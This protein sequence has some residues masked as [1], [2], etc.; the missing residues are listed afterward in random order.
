[1]PAN[2]DAVSH[3]FSSRSRA[4]AGFNVLLALDGQGFC[5]TFREMKAENPN[6]FPWGLWEAELPFPAG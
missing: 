2:T 1:M 3:P 4:L 6:P 5:N